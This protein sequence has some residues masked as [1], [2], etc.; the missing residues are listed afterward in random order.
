MSREGETQ[1][2]EPLEGTGSTQVSDAMTQ[3]SAA[4]GQTLSQ[5]SAAKSASEN[6]MKK[7]T[8]GKAKK[9]ADAPTTA[10]AAAANVL[11][12]HTAFINTGMD[13]AQ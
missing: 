11:R 1:R 9:P 12:P 2:G 10:A 8:R 4:L 5:P 7:K 13:V 3:E 6:T